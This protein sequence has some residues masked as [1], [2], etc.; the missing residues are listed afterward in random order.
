VP[1]THAVDIQ[2]ISP[3]FDWLIGTQNSRLSR[4]TTKIW[5]PN[6]AIQWRL[7]GTIAIAPQ[8]VETIIFRECHPLQADI[9]IV[10][11]FRLIIAQNLL[12]T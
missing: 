10:N 5:V 1:G 4:P 12:L 6:R 8:P 9:V 3:S 7:S 11:F 2:H